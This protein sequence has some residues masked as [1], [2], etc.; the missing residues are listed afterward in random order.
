M[1]L[2]SGW[3]KLR[4]KYLGCFSKSIVITPCQAHVWL[5]GTRGSKTGARRRKITP[6]AGDLQLAELNWGDRQLTVCTEKNRLEDYQ[7]YIWT[8]GNS[9]KLVP[10]LLNDGQ[11]CC[12][13]VCND[14]IERFQAEPGLLL[15]Y[16][17][18]YQ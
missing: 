1:N 9:A 5:S 13:L 17:L 12:M 6:G 2:W 4:R 10:I 15:L 16:C 7:P 18:F 11:E 8:C 3:G 14:F